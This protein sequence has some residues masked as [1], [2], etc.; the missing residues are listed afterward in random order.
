MPFP[1]GWPPRAP[2]GV[3]TLRAY[4][5][6]TATA[7]YSDRAYLFIDLTGANPFTPLPDVRPG[8]D[9]SAPDYSGPHVVPI[10]PAGTGERGDDPK[11]MI[12][13]QAIQ[14]QNFGA[15]AIYYSFDGT[16][17]HGQVPPAA[18]GIPGEV[19]MKDRH[20]AGIAIRGSGNNFAVT[21]W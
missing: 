21:A 1:D 19:I 13:S 6:A 10:A 12:W 4:V 7:N 17:D 18:S 20:E 15:T 11:A 14:I 9:V 3:R 2:S 5:A 16:N 8:E